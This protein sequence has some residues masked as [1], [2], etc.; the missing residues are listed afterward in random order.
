MIL[1]FLKMVCAVK[2]QHESN[3]QLNI[4][5]TYQIF[6]LLDMI[7]HLKCFKSVFIIIYLKMI[8]YLYKKLK[9][10]VVNILFNN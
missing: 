3:N 7:N 5:V 10:K 4:N 2:K 9:F 8:Y 6:K 1:D